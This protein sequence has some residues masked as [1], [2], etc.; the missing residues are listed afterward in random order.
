VILPRDADWFVVEPCLG[1]RLTVRVRFPAA[2]CDLDLVVYGDDGE[3]LGVSESVGD[4]EA[5]AVDV[6][7]AP[8]LL[9]EVYGL[10]GGQCTYDLE[11]RLTGCGGGDDRFEDNDGLGTARLLP[12]GS[13]VDLAL[14]PGD[15]DW[16]SFDICAGGV[17]T[18]QIAFWH[19]QGDLDLGLYTG[20]GAVV[21]A[22]TSA[23]DDEWVQVRANADAR[24]YVRVVDFQGQGNTYELLAL[25]VGCDG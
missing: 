14:L 1:G 21:A 19:A 13:Y 10:G 16:F 8:T 23:D 9:V 25:L 4:E 20:G 11:V 7:L 15:E 2:D 18:V 3:V 24:G 5:V 17:L 6:G 22:S 12:P